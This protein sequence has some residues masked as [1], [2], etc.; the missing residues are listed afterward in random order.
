MLV[1]GILLPE[2]NITE[3]HV[4]CPSSICLTDTWILSYTAACIFKLT[5]SVS[6]TQRLFAIYFSMIDILHG[7]IRWV[8]WCTT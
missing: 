3:K 2:K 1:L 6:I 7:F 8:I 5:P 4:I